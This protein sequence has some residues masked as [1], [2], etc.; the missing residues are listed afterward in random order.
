MTDILINGV[1]F[2]PTRVRWQGR[3][4]LGVQGDGRPIYPGIRSLVLEWTFI[5]FSTWANL[6]NI[7]DIIQSTGSISVQV[8]AFPTGTSQTFGYTEYSGVHI[9]EPDV[10]PNFAEQFPSS[11]VLVISNIPVTES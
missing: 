6:Q 8:P 10:G 1:T 11:M 2:C 7:Y 4:P 3:R 9:S 5:N